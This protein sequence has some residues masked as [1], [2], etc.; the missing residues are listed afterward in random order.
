M[1]IRL[2]IIAALLGMT[3]CVSIASTEPTRISASEVSRVQD[4]VKSRLRD[5]GSATFSNISAQNR[6]LTDGKTQ[7]IICGL[8]NSKNGFGGYAGATAFSVF[9]DIEGKLS[10]GTI[11]ESN[12][13]GVAL[14]GHCQT[15]ALR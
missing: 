12:Q 2:V 7:T 10:L 4:I 9:K 3:G 15:F 6:V 8:V 14:D 1:R 11:D 5:P 13:L